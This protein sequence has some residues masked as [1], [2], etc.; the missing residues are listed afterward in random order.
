LDLSSFTTP[1]VESF[2]AMFYGCESLTSLDISG[3]TFNEIVMSSSEKYS[4]LFSS[5]SANSVVLVGSEKEQNWIL[6]TASQEIRPAGWNTNNV[7][8]KQV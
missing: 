6:V 5:L 3:F 8:V 2:A 7:V 1:N 4:E